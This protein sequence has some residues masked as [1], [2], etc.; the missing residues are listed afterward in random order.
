MTCHG[1][2]GGTGSGSILNALLAAD[3]MTGRDDITA[4]PST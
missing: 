4:A 1:F 3:T 2:K